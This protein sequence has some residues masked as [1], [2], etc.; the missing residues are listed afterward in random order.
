[1]N[2]EIARSS[3]NDRF[4]KISYLLLGALLSAA[5]V[6]LIPNIIQGNYNSLNDSLQKKIAFF[7][8]GMTGADQVP[9]AKNKIN[10]DSPKL[11]FFYKLDNSQNDMSVASKVSDHTGDNQNDLNKKTLPSDTSSLLPNNSRKAQGFDIS[12]K[13]PACM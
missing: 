2:K 9:K 3:E 6:L 12:L 8:N 11:T 7:M 13:I 1:M 5:L 4:T 10:Q